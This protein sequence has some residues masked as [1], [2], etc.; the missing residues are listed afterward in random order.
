MDTMVWNIKGV[1]SIQGAVTALRHNVDCS[2]SPQCITR[3]KAF[4]HTIDILRKYRAV[5][6]ELKAL[7]NAPDKGIE[8]IAACEKYF[9]AEARRGY[10][11]LSLKEF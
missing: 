6:E 7:A 9:L 8:Y 11:K 3:R 10:I 5:M 2:A 4:G 1:Y